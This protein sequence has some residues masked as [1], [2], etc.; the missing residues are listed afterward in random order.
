M[1]LRSR[2]LLLLGAIAL[3][4]VRLGTSDLWLPDEPRYAQIAEELRSM[5]QGAA[6]LVLL[7]LNGEA[8][9]QKP[10]LFF[11]LAAAA[12]APEGRVDEWAARLPSAVAGVLAIAATAALGTRLFGAATG[13]LGGA[14]LL[15]LFTF[16]FAAR[17]AQLDMLLTLFE[18][19]ALAAFARVDAA[20]RPARRDLVALHGAL[21]LAVLT[22]GPVGWLVPVLVIVV[23]LLWERRIGD[24]RRAFPAWGLALALAPA[25]AWLAV[26][27]LLA[28]PGWLGATVVDNVLGRF[29]AGNSHARPLY[30]EL[31]KLPAQ[32]L[33]WA[34]LVLLVGWAAP[35]A[36]SGP[37]DRRRAWRL[38]LAWVVTTL[39]FFSLSA[40]KRPRY[41]MTSFPAY[42]LLMADAL[43]AALAAV[44]RPRRALGLGGAAYALG[45]VAFAIWVVHRNALDDP[46]RSL[47]FASAAVALI[48]ASGVAWWALARRGADAARLLAVPIGT[49]YV[50]LLVGHT[51][52]VPQLGAS[53]SPR[54]I[55]ARAAA[56]AREGEPIGVL[57]DEALGAAIAYYGDRRVAMLS[58]PKSVGW[59]AAS[60]GRVLVLAEDRLAEVDAAAP[61]RVHDRVRLGDDWLLVAIVGEA[62][63]ER[64]TELP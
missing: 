43:R 29:V 64:R 54:T 55:A 48:A 1:S 62:L 39:V 37:A 5:Q 32:L 23:F 57:G 13:T 36:L 34:P 10:P 16:A 30:Y 61:V 15:T 42:T 44:R 63:A 18:T 49:A 17:T 56:L 21:G 24:L 40:G 46:E 4:G 8:Y 14:L 2:S 3:F 45:A 52:I 20:E 33:P 6:G 11:W 50:A 26:A 19:L 35:A 22:K 41:L 31:E 9:T 47:R 7:H 27:G 12:G 38:A 28:P 25:L 58:T 51:V 53:R 60:G 59:F